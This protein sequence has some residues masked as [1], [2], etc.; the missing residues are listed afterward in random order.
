MRNRANRLK[1]TSAYAGNAVPMGC[2]RFDRTDSTR[3]CAMKWF[4]RIGDACWSC[5]RSAAGR[6]LVLRRRR[7]RAGSGDLQDRH[8]GLARAGRA[9][10][11]RNCRPRSASRSSGAI[12]CRSPRCRRAR[13]FEEYPRVRA[14]VP[15]QRADGQRRS[16]T[17]R[18]TR[19]SRRRRSAARRRA[20]DEAAYGRVIAAMGVAAKV[21]VTHEHPDHIGGV[22]RFPRAG[23]A[24]PNGLC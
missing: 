19:T 16:S 24:W 15:A 5:S 3:E 17:P 2:D 10:T 6:L 1:S 14:V 7:R 13:A 12:R 4:E 23:A 11:P 18:W 9:A 21:A 22:A 8:R 20:F